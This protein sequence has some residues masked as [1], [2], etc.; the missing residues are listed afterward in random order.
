VNGHRYLGGVATLELDRD[1]CTGCQVCL[2]VCPHAVFEVA[3]DRRVRIAD[4]D[5]CMECGA[6]A[7]NCAFDAITL[8]PGVGCAAAIIYG[9]INHTEP[10]CGCSDDASTPASACCGSEPQSTARRITP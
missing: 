2:A 1:K 6:C 3:E 5:A 9:W 10:S 7:N 8:T 4:L